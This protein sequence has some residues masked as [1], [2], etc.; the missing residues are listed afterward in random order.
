MRCD[1]MEKTGSMTRRP[2]NTPRLM[3]LGLLRSLTRFSCPPGAWGNDCIVPSPR[4]NTPPT[5]LP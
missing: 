5:Y 1:A 3:R 4:Q 2:Y